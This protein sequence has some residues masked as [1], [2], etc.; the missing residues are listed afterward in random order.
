MFFPI[1]IKS[2]KHW[3]LGVLSFLDRS[4]SVYDSA[5][6]QVHA[7]DVINVVRAYAKMLPLFMGYCGVF[8]Q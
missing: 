6:N 3:V 1:Y 8:A 7:A 2:L 5:P 4:I